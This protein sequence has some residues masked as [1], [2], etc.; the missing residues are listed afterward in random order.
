MLGTRE[1]ALPAGDVDSN[2][3]IPDRPIQTKDHSEGDTPQLM[4]P[5]N[6]FNK[7]KV[8]KNDVNDELLPDNWKGDSDQS[9]H[10]NNDGK[11][12]DMHSQCSVVLAE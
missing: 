3:L 1:E 9:F 5:T 10:I 6:W 4:K 12:S 11:Y 8:K 2:F 7:K